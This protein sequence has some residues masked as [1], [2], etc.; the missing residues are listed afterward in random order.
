MTRLS[1]G[2]LTVSPSAARSVVVAAGIAALFELVVLRLLTRTAVFIPGISERIG[3]V[4]AVGELGRLAYSVSLALLGTGLL[5]LAVLAVRRSSTV[6]RAV[7]VGLIAFGAFALTARLGWIP[8]IAADVMTLASFILVASVARP[9]RP[10]VAVA[11]VAFSLAFV[12]AA[13]DAIWR[14]IGGQTA[15]PGNGGVLLNL[16]E[17]L[18][19]GAALA[20]IVARR[21]SSGGS[22]VVGVVMGGA[23]LMGLIVA[24]ASVRILLL[25][26]VGLPG[27]LPSVAY[28]AVTM[29]V[30]VTIVTAAR[31]GQLA[32]AAGVTLLAT[33]GLGLQSTYQSGLV[34]VGLAA[35]A[36][37]H[38]LDGEMR[39][40][41][42]VQRRRASP[43]RRT[44]GP[45]G[46]APPGY[47]MKEVR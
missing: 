38:S 20:A 18:V 6:G 15:I 2:M 46:L 4:S 1:A 17:W 25:W 39:G 35:L 5:I 37:R 7:A 32:T 27:A 36:L 29:A 34:L 22:L 47:M 10:V 33:G 14:N 13:V 8:R 21:R 12:L 43:G 45:L 11:V 42:V 16:A 44:T 24:S 41:T 19:A 9:R 31:R 28:G 30:G 3:V 26:N 23:L 40:P